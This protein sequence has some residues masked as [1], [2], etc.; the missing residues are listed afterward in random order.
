MN[1]R[2]QESRALELEISMGR[3]W[4]LLSTNDYSL[5][6]LQVPAH[7]RCKARIQPVPRDEEGK[8]PVGCLIDGIRAVSHRDAFI[9]VHRCG[10]RDADPLQSPVYVAVFDTHDCY[11]PWAVGRVT[12]DDPMLIELESTGDEDTYVTVTLHYELYP[13]RAAPP[14]D[15]H[16]IVVQPVDQDGIFWSHANTDQN[17]AFPSR[18]PDTRSLCGEA[19]K[20]AELKTYGTIWTCARCLQLAEQ[21]K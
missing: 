12:A 21:E 5:F 9:V 15:D 13:I 2:N 19:T 1:D 17:H 20:P 10:R 3:S 4:T 6:R 7:G 16:V 14:G 8:A 18:E 11:C